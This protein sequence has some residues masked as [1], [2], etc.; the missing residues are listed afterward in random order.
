VASLKLFRDLGLHWWQRNLFQIYQ[1]AKGTHQDQQ[2]V[3]PK[4]DGEELT[5][6][7]G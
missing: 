1:V 4:S 3:P 2:G 5:C 6:L 7:L